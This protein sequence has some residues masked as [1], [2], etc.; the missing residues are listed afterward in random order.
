MSEIGQKIIAAVRDVANN[1]PGHVYEH[2][3]CRY[4]VDGRPACLI[5]HALWNVGLISGDIEKSTCNGEAVDYVAAF[6]GLDIDG[7]ERD[8]LSNAQEVQDNGKPW[9]YAV[10]QAD[11][12]EAGEVEFW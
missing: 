1:D 2:E 6:L 4:V 7:S 10:Q 12:I 9:E 11:G 3:K 5:G 8:W